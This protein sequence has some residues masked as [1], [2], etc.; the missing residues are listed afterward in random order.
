M[1]PEFLAGSEHV[2]HCPVTNPT[3]KQWIYD[4]ELYLVKDDTKYATSGTVSFTLAAGAS[5]T[6]DFPI[7]M[8]GSEGTY[9]VY[10]D[11][12]VA[13]ELIAAYQATEPV[14]VQAPLSVPV[15][16]K[17]FVVTTK[18]ADLGP[19][20]IHCPV[21]NEGEG[22]GT[23]TVT[24][25]MDGALVES[26]TFTIAPGETYDYVYPWS[27]APE[28]ASGTVWVVGDWGVETPHIYFTAG[29]SRDVEAAVDCTGVTA[30][31]AILRF[32][33]RSVTNEWRIS[34]DGARTTI[35]VDD[36]WLTM[37]CALTGLLPKHT[38]EASIS[39]YNYGTRTDW[40]TFTTR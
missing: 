4:A 24:L 28:G 40:T 20:E 12:Y 9:N 30:T 21:K 2:A 15:I 35:K 14:V 34:Y 36:H 31:T 16:Q 23:H 19:Y 25:Y 29:Y 17:F 11:I 37:W 3:A 33:A 22:T 5:A 32:T 10:L 39:G 13:G 7:T 27:L 26:K 6:V 38:Y 1:D 8:P 18:S